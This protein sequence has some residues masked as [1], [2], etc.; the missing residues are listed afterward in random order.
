METIELGILND[1]PVSQSDDVLFDLNANGGD[2]ETGN[3]FDSYSFSLDSPTSITISADADTSAESPYGVSFLVANEV[4]NEAGDLVGLGYSDLESLEES[5]E[6]FQANLSPGKYFILVSPVPELETDVSDLSFTVNY[7]LDI[8]PTSLAADTVVDNENVNTDNTEIDIPLEDGIINLPE[9]DDG[10]V[11]SQVIENNFVI[12]NTYERGSE[13]DSYQF[14]IAQSGTYD[15]EL[16]NLEANLDLSIADREGNTL[17]SSAESGNQAEFIAAD[18]APGSYTASITGEGD[19]ETSYSFSITK[20]SSDGGSD[21]GGNETEGDRDSLLGEG[22]L[23]YRF[24]E[25]EAGTQFYTTSEVERDSIIDN[26]PN[27]Q[28]EGESFIGAPNSAENDITGVLPVYRFFN[29]STG[30]HLYT[31]SEIERDAVTANLP[32]YTPEGISYYGYESQVE[33]STAL[34]RF[35]NPG[36]DAHFYTPSIAERDQFLASAEYQP[37]GGEDGIAY[38]VQPIEI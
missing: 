31:A 12:V 19:V 30:V 34:Y 26:L 23:V 18:F 36:L 13:E 25:T 5:E 17:Y 14:E 3:F 38:Y 9:S 6:V 29:T 2:L 11:N 32:N 20:T 28:F 35:Y 15:V 16:T 10:D 27:Y 21:S 8:N 22:D 33:G 24:R 7:T 4:N 1:T 37:E